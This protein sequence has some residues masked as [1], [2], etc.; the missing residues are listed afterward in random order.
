MF[1]MK[2]KSDS[3]CGGLQRI[4]SNSALE[5]NNTFMLRSLE[6]PGRRQN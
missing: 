3:F 2:H 4:R 6:A 1:M 5:I